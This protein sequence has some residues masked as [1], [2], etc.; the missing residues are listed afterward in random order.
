MDSIQLKCGL[1]G[2]ENNTV[3]LFPRWTRNDTKRL[4]DSMTE[5]DDAMSQYFDLLR[6][7]VASC[8]LEVYAP[9]G[10]VTGTIE[11]ADDLNDDTIDNL[12]EVVFGWL[13]GV[14]PTFVG[15]RRNLGNASALVSLSTKEPMLAQSQNHA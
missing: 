5:S 4:V 9:D 15:A 7:K 12:D 6:E 14:L 2:Y 8:H 3:D 1:D 10:S 11:S 13:C